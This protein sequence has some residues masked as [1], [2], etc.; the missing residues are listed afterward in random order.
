MVDVL[1]KTLPLISAIL[2]G[3]V[4]IGYAIKKEWAWS[5]VWISYAL[6][7]IGLVAAAWEK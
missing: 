5:F 2:Y 4:G 7:N 1:V 6:A 3:V